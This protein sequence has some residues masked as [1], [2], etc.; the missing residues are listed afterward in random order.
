[1]KNGVRRPKRPEL[2]KALLLDAG[3]QLLV[4]GG[5]L[6]IGAV[7]EIADVTTSSL[8]FKT[9]LQTMARAS[10]QLGAMPDWLLSPLMK[11]RPITAKRF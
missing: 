11:R 3:A 2:V 6:S 10:P 7:A 1:M 8:S 5:Q 4:H 9:E